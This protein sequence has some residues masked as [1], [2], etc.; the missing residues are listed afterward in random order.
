M[1]YCNV[2]AVALSHPEDFSSAL[3]NLRALNV[4][5]AHSQCFSEINTE[6]EKRLP[7]IDI[8]RTGSV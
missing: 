2:S 7:H 4:I 6:Q 8:V 3:W 1:L 5:C